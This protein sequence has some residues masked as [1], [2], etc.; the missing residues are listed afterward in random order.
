MGLTITRH[1]GDAVKID[2]SEATDAELLSL[3][4]ADVTLSVDEAR[5]GQVRVTFNAPRFVRFWRQE[6]YDTF[7][8]AKAIADAKATLAAVTVL[9][10]VK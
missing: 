6:H 5:R 1:N 2:L 10:G 7:H 4:H 8:H 9:G 3:R